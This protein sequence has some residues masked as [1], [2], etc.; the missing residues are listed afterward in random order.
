M[1]VNDGAVIGVG[2]SGGEGG[3]LKRQIGICMCQIIIF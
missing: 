2:D 3:T 1:E